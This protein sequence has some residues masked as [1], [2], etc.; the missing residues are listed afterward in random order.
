MYR[1]IPFYSKTFKQF[2]YD[3]LR[4]QPMYFSRKM[5]CDRWLIQCYRIKPTVYD[6]DV[7]QRFFIMKRNCI[8]WIIMVSFSWLC[9]TW[10]VNTQNDIKNN[11]WV[12]VNN[13]FWVRVR[14]FANNFHE[15]RSHE[16]KSLANRITSDPKIVIHGNECIILFLARYLMSWTLNSAKTIIDNWF[17]RCR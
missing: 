2:W 3:L 9:F 10:G 4:F 1:L 14:R 17:R 8:S 6:N 7:T 5:C 12:T 15:W 16:W 13:D 11:A